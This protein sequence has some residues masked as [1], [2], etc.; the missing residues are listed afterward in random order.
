M[1][2][3]K[4]ARVTD[5]LHIV[6]IFNDYF[7]SIAEKTKVKTKVSNKSF[8]G[9]LH[10]SNEEL[11][12]SAAPDAHEVSLIISSLN[13][14]KSTGTNSLLTKILKPLKIRFLLT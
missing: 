14:N 1:L 3:L 5:P 10:H 2:T 9:F 6:N 7:S 12:F 13:S 4:S 11:L 8:Q